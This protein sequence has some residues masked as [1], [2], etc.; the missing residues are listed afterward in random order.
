MEA[1]RLRERRGHHLVRGRNCV[2][3]CE[4]YLS[5]TYTAD[6]PPQIDYQ[7][8]P[9]NYNFPTLTPEL[10]ASGPRPGHLAR[11]LKYDFTVYNSAGRDWSPPLA[12]SPPDDWTVPAGVPVVGADL[13]LDRAGLR[14]G[15]TLATTAT[16]TTSPRRSR[17]R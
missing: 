8:P 6:T 13:L 15:R 4:P 14:R 1:V 11:S 2:G 16:T 5:L 10:M 7:Y 3:N 9:G 12:R 17:S